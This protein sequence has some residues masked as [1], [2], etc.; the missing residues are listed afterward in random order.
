[1]K[2]NPGKEAY[3]PLKAIGFGFAA[4]AEGL[5]YNFQRSFQ[6]GE[7]CW[8]AM[9]L[10]FPVG[11][12]TRDRGNGFNEL[13]RFR[14]SGRRDERRLK[15]TPHF[16]ADAAT[17][18]FLNQTLMQLAGQPEGQYGFASNV[19]PFPSHISL[20]LAVCHTR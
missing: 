3:P 1:M 16:L 9:P 8:V 7:A 18:A 15:A 5:K 12:K 4:W 13:T 2:G 6:Q 20:V 14:I 10:T 19:L 11:E 17:S